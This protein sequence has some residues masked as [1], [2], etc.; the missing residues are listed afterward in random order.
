M[1]CLFKTFI[2][3]INI[4]TILYVHSDVQIFCLFFF[5]LPFFL[6]TFSKKFISFYFIINYFISFIIYFLPHTR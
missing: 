6:L 1:F 3:F 5:L 4:C 2:N